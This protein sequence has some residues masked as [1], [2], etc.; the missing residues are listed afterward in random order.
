M[1]NIWNCSCKALALFKPGLISIRLHFIILLSGVYS[2]FVKNYVIYIYIYIY[3]Y[4]RPYHDDILLIS[5]CHDTYVNNVLVI[6][7]YYY[8]MYR[9]FSLIQSYPPSG[10]SLLIDCILLSFKCQY[11]NDNVIVSESLLTIAI[12]HFIFHVSVRLIGRSLHGFDI[13]ID[14]IFSFTKVSYI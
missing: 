10:C 9:I 1:C 4:Q 3:I 13:L 14:R 8:N 5:I 2:A 6:H 11:C 12:Q 7:H